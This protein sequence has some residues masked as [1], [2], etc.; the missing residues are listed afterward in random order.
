MDGQKMNET[1]NVKDIFSNLLLKISVTAE[2][3]SYVFSNN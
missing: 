2:K 1:R 3:K